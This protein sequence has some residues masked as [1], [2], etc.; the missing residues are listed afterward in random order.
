MSANQPTLALDFD[1]V[2]CDGMI[3]YFQ[4]AWRTYC[5]IW[6]PDN[7][8]PADDLAPKFYRT[9]PVIETGWEMPVL[10]RE[11]VKGTSETEIL[12]DW[13]TIAKQTI[14]EENLDPKMLST[15]LDGIRD[16]WISEDLPSWLSLH[17]FYPGVIER[18]KGF[19][20]M[21]LQLYIITTKEERFV[22]SLLEKEGVHLEKG[23]IFGKGEKRPKYE[24]LRELLAGVQPTP[25][26]W[27]VEDRLKTLLTVQQQ[28]DLGDVRLFLADWGYNTESE[29]NSVAEYPGIQLLSLSQF[30]DD[31]SA[32][33]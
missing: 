5:R 23:R 13:Q 15:Q 2:V 18:V 9:R 33:G 14:T 25:D 7:S 12:N 27:F 24:I 4:T 1:G 17:R 20:E 16:R 26:I 8:I 32:W 29:R 31:F 22:R 19:L 10:V 11:L 6:S 28:P 21:G 3:E 30:T